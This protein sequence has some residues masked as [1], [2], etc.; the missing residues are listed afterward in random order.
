MN[1]ENDKFIKFISSQLKPPTTFDEQINKLK[2]RN[3]VIE[4]ENFAKEVLKRINYYH[5][6][7]YLHDFKDLAND[8]Y[9]KELTFDYIYKIIKFD[10]RIRNIFLY[11]MEIIERD[12][13]T[14]ISYNFAHSYSEGN[15]S[16][17]F[18]RD[19]KDKDKHS[20]FISFINKNIRDNEELPFIQHHK[21]NYQGYHP[22]WVAIE[23]FTLG[24]LE[25]FYVLL[26]NSVQKKIAKEYGYSKIQFGNWIEAMRRFRNM[27]AHDMRLYNYKVVSTPAKT[28]EFPITTYKIFDYVLVMRIL[29]R[30]K[31]EWNNKILKDIKNTFNE[32][33]EVIDI[34]CIGFPEDWE[35]YLKIDNK[36][37]ENHS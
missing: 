32:F 12:L 17:M 36:N 25:N 10:M 31:E 13:K 3:L 9:P 11:G 19:F 7:G 8:C 21:L 4:N 29:I 28:K 37:I 18:S 14:S 2:N 16:Y 30:D 35:S 5:F 27:L 34:S 15:I 1:I 26:D 33:L 24:N 22:I 20:K 6:T 23:L